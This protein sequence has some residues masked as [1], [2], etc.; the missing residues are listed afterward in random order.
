[1]AAPCGSVEAIG[2]PFTGVRGVLL[3]RDAPLQ[4][5]EKVRRNAALL[6]EPGHIWLAGL[7]Q[8]IAELERRWT[9]KVG[10]PVGRG[11]EAFVA[12]AHAGGG[13]DVI[14]KIVIPGIDPMRQ[15]LRI[16]RAA[17][18]VG[19]VRLICR[20]EVS[21]AMLLER[22]GPQLH[23]F[24]LPEDQQIEIMCG[25]L[26][27]AWRPPPKGPSLPTGADKAVELSRAIESHWVSFGRPCLE[28]TIE[29][30]LSYAER[31]RRAFDPARSVLVHGDAHEWNT[32][33][34]PGS[35]T[36]FKFVDPDGVFAE[37]AFD[38]AIPMREWGNVMPEGD[39][40]RRGR[41]RCNLSAKFAGVR[42]QPIWEWG[43]IQCVWNGLLLHRIGLDEPASV[44]LAIA[45]VWSAAG[46]S[47]AR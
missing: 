24:H 12:K 29:L 16:L 32:L 2:E 8:Y 26:R 9:I 1:M 33:M 11:S 28:R 15:E 27:E 42:H 5:P 40:V 44:S 41:H 36:G 22:L 13:L 17:H 6:G 47:V 43:L 4:I 7:P 46:D 37:R 39:V 23:E 18:G 31:R 14:L 34:A 38:L 10:Q 3:K 21:N 19:Y 25:T 45:D 30:A 35:A 20:D